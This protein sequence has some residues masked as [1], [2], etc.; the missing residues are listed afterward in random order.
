MFVFRILRVKSTKK[1][2]LIKNLYVMKKAVIG[3]DV[4]FK[5]FHVC[6]LTR[7]D[8]NRCRVLASRTFENSEA[9]V[10]AMLKWVE[11]HNK[12]LLETSY[13][14]EAT[15]C[16]YENL[17]YH[18]HEKGEKVSVVL[19]N[20]MKNYFKSLNIKTKTDKVDARVIAQYG[21]ERALELWAPLSEDFKSLRDMCREILAQK[22]EMTR[23]K[24]QLH[25]IKF[26]HKKAEVVKEVKLE[27]IE[28][29]ERSIQLLRQEV[30]ALVGEDENLKAKIDKLLTIPGIGFET[31]IILV[32]ETNGFRL[33]KNIRQVVS[34]AGLDVSHR[35]SGNYRGR[36]KISKKG[37]SRIRQAL[38][39]PALSATMNNPSIKNLH[40][41]I[42]EKNPKIK[43]KGTVA[44]MRKLLVFAYVIWKKDEQYDRG[45]QWSA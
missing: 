39:M 1:Y 19:A 5:D 18:L 25:A 30:K 40:E 12:S 6:F 2:S 3:I 45:Y 20:K 22:K 34:Y 21:A 41:R 7:D 17:A 33:F 31:A 44:S 26:S 10:E 27:Q 24:N 14:M 9:G 43:K 13:V 23:A 15:G 11:K 4:S 36:S 32:C 28:L 35:E 8:D 42:C 37:N 38:F 16:Y 29:Y